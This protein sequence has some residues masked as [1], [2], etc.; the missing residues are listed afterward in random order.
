MDQL[1]AFNTILEYNFRFKHMIVHNCPCYKIE[2]EKFS[3]VCINNKSYLACVIIKKGN[4]SKLLHLKLPIVFGSLIDYTIR[5]D[6]MTNYNQFGC[7]YLDGCLKVIY[8]FISNNLTPGHV[9]S[10]EK[11]KEQIFKVNIEDESF[12]MHLIYNPGTDKADA[13]IQPTIIDTKYEKQVKLE[14]HIKT[15]KRTIEKDKMYKK[16]EQECEPPRK[17]MKSINIT[18]PQVTKSKCKTEK[19]LEKLLHEQK[20]LQVE[21]SEDCS[22][23][24]TWLTLL[25]RVGRKIRSHVTI[26]NEREFGENDHTEIFDAYLKYAP[27]LDDISNKVNRT[28]S[29]IMHR[30][31]MHNIDICYNSDP[32]LK[33]LGSKLT[34]TFKNGNMYYTLAQYLNKDSKLVKGFKSIYQNI[35]AQKLNLGAMMTSTVKRSVSDSIKNSKALLFS[36]DGYWFIC[37]I[38]SREMKGAGENVML[39]QMVIVPIG[40][41]TDKVV[42]F[43]IEQQSV[44][45]QGKT[46]LQC[47]INSFLQ[48]FHVA[49]SKL[50][51]LKKKFPTISLMIFDRFLIINTTGYNQM[52]YSIKYECFMNTFEYEHIWKDAFDNYHPHL[53]CNTAAMF[54]PEAIEL[55]LPAKLTVANANVK[56]ACLNI[57][58]VLELVMF[59]HTNGASNAALIHRAERGDVLALV[60]FDG[61]R[62]TNNH[63]ILIPIKLKN[64][65]LRYMNLGNIGK[66]NVKDIPEV[67]KSIHGV[68]KPKEDMSE[69]Y[70]MRMA[71][72][73][74]D[75][76][77]VFGN[78]YK[79]MYDLYENDTRLE[80]I[81]TNNTQLLKTDEPLL[82]T[83]DNKDAEQIIYDNHLYHIKGYIRQNHDIKDAYEKLLEFDINKNHPPQMYIP[84]AF[85]DIEGGTN[86]DGIVVD[87]KLVKYGPK[88]LISQTLN[89][90]Y[91]SD[92]K[93]ET[94]NVSY[95]KIGNVID[96]EIVFGCLT[97][98]MKI[99]F[100]KTKNT[101]IREIYIAP[102]SYQYYISVRNTSD[103]KKY[104]S[105]TFSKKACSINIHYSYLVSIGVGTKLCTS[106]G[107]KGIVC[108]VAD[109]SSL[110]GYT[111]D[112]TMVHPLLLFSPTSVLGRTMASQVYSMMTQPTRA[113]T[114]SGVLISPHGINVHNIDP[115]IKT[116]V[117]EV[118]NDLMTT[119]N[120]FVFNELSYTMKILSTQKTLRKKELHKMH[121]VSQLLALQ[122]INLKLMSFDSVVMLMGS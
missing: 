22:N 9:Y 76:K 63:K 67:V 13:Q 91:K 94:A 27:K 72:L 75:A 15:L 106:H 83:N 86:E 2:Y 118:K 31:L 99:T 111:K 85:G 105:S 93:K 104:T 89:I 55:G 81:N 41:E 112:G 42:S 45:I 47:V 110:V 66:V 8:N 113:F 37:P 52:K 7:L 54:L 48:P 10:N 119:E 96:S 5:K 30:A 122:G 46:L 95:H 70:G 80:F 59:L 74:K 62:D 12:S 98:S 21:K 60:T 14:Q 58:S 17:K 20:E 38:D 4:I 97:S 92:S 116:K 35:E 71:D 68:F 108:K 90:T 103:F 39:A 117:S 26:E 34:N 120:G 6:E 115:S 57:N 19:K 40:I 32:E 78:I 1:N 51:M 102:S 69:A 65:Q 49:H 44:L 33:N 109:L 88:K 43:I 61:H 29:Y 79:I 64:P 82:L 100:S 53:K 50:L 84:V 23:N 25:N 16:A 56:G 18:K 73:M 77:S 11:K 121:Y 101:I 3:N 107:Q 114:E 24:I 36:A 87:E 28:L